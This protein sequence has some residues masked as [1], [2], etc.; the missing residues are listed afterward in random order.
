MKIK[1]SLILV[2]ILAEILFAQKRDSLKNFNLKE[3]TVQ[4]ESVIEPKPTTKLGAQVLSS[5]DGNSLFEIA[6]YIPSLKYQTNSR[7]ESLFYLRGSNE[8]QLG[9]FFDGALLNIPWDNRID[10]SL[11][12]TSNLESIKLIKGVPSSIYGAN[13]IAGV[14]VSNSKNVVSNKLT[15]NVSAQFGN[16]GY[17][18]IATTLAQ[19]INRFSILL[20]ANY[21]NKNSFGLSSKFNNPE[22]SSN[23]RINSYQTNLSAYSK[24]GFEYKNMSNIFISFQYLDSQKGV[25]PEIGVSK[26]RFWKYPEWNKIGFNVFG[27]H[28]F[29]FNHSSFLDYYVSYYNFKMQINQYTDATY[30]K[31]DDIEKNNDNVLFARA[32][33]T[34]LLNQNSIF[35]FS[36]SGYLTNHAESFLSNNFANVDYQQYVYSA[37]AEYEL[38]RNN[39]TFIAGISLDGINSLKTGN[40][41]VKNNLNSFGANSTLKYNLTNALNLRI[42]VGHKSR[43]PSLRESYSDGLGRFVVN[44]QL[45]PEVVND[46][47]FGIEYNNATGRLLLNFLFTNL[48]DGIVRSSI[49]TINGS[50]FMRINK[51]EIRTLGFE[52]EGNKSLNKYFYIGFSFSYLNSKA[53][54]DAGSFSD[55]LEYRP[56]VISN[57]F[58]KSQITSNFNLLLESSFIAKEFALIE[59]SSTL[60]ELPSYYLL[61]VR[62]SYVFS[63][64]KK[65]SFEIFGRINNVFDKLY[66]TQVGLPEAGR[67]FFVGGRLKF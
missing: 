49:Q 15:G 13:N 8:R 46:F 21:F 34:M 64:N 50:K 33:F 47:E 2:F 55:T 61:N 39:L 63:L 6:K 11:L 56:V 53:K 67:E 1:F 60:N 26:A 14:I 54:N 41:D 38:I 43:F 57:L 10:L 28:T 29:D 24:V 65:N 35:R 58:L 32:I 3:I 30:S 16:Y 7:G 17:K 18:H 36:T 4:S 48:K 12:P 44:P 37:G 42:N 19:K 22:N 23:S 45:K 66:Y 59:G 40:F 9:L 52:I 20:S 27:K 62:T 31:Y 25:P 51:S 5:Y